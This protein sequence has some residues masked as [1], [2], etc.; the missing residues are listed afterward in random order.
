MFDRLRSRYFQLLGTWFAKEVGIGMKANGWKTVAV[1]NFGGGSEVESYSIRDRVC[2]ALASDGASKRE[3]VFVS[4]QGISNL[5]KGQFDLLPEQDRKSIEQS[6]ADAIVFGTIGSQVQGYIFDTRRRQTQP[7]LTVQ[8]ISAIPG[9][10]SNSDG[11]ARLP[12]KSSTSRGLRVEAW[13]EKARYGVGSE[14]TF[15][16]RSNRDCYVM[17]LDLQTSG[18]LYVL[19]PNSYQKEN[20]VRGGKIYSIPGSQAPF[21]INA[22]G[23]T[24]IEGVK[25]IASTKPL[26]LDNWTAVS[27]FVAARTPSQQDE[28]CSG[29]RSTVKG[30][31]DDEWDVAEWT[32]EITK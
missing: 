26:S 1:A 25:A 22:S 8:A 24:G 15:Y 2:S 5:Q 21:S 10:P 14:V 30:L 16:L 28:L 32:F 3:L 19:F 31:S 23:P 7:V 17:L 27:T 12:S 9:F 29:I 20:F 13:T 18:G 11:W 6:G 4:D